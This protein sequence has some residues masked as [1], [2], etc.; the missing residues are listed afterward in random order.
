MSYPT[1]AELK[2][3]SDKLLWITQEQYENAVKER[4]NAQSALGD[5]K[6]I[7]IDKFRESMAKTRKNGIAVTAVRD[8]AKSEC[9]EW[10]KAEILAESEYH[11]ARM[12][13]DYLHERIQTIKKI[14]S[15]NEGRF[16]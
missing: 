3:N 11:K 2:A 6:A 4:I 13:C 10:E 14:M 5:A 8:I 12:K 7:Y 1:L 15:E 16:N 9:G